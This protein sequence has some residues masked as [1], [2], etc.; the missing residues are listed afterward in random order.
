MSNTYIIRIFVICAISVAITKQQCEPSLRNHRSTASKACSIN[1]STV[2]LANG[3]VSRQRARKKMSGDVSES[4]SYFRR[5]NYF[6]WSPRARERGRGKKGRWLKEKKKREREKGGVV[7]ETEQGRSGRYHPPP[8]AP[9]KG[10]QRKRR[11]E[12]AENGRNKTV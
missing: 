1:P 3:R 11:G 2:K 7:K 12:G 6:G 10:V 4:E 8:P 5:V 9:S